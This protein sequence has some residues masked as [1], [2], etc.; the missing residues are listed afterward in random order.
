MR[1]LSFLLLLF[2]G[3]NHLSAADA[4]ATPDALVAALYKAHDNDKSPFFQTDDKA[5]LNKFFNKELADLIW[6]DAKESKGEVGVL[7]F[8]PLY[9][10]QDTEIKKFAIQEAKVEG[11][12]A[13]VPVGFENMGEKQRVVFKL[14][15]QGGV[16]KISDIQY[17]AGHTLL[18]LY[19]DA[20]KEN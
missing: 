19:K 1:A 18:G 11:E 10:A 16:W 17:T 5:P 7:G 8:D 4:A 12:K 20:A 13:T 2:L 6:K 14:V 9:D 3:L 15:K